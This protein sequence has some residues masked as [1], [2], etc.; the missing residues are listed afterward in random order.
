MGLIETD[1]LAI[2]RETFDKMDEAGKQG[3]I[4]DYLSAIHKE[5]RQNCSNIDAQIKEMSEDFSVRIL[6]VEN[7]LK[8]FEEKFSNLKLKGAVILLLAMAAGG[9]GSLTVEKILT[10]FGI[11]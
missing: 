10:L 9:T 7:K 8:M 2:S 11:K 6:A 5:Q 3:T 4:Y 1:G